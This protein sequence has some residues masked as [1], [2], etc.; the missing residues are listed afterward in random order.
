MH[1]CWILQ[2]Q[3]VKQKTFNRDRYHWWRLKRQR[4]SFLSVIYVCNRLSCHFCL[5]FRSITFISEF[6]LS[7]SVVLMSDCMTISVTRNADQVNSKTS[8]DAFSWLKYCVKIVL[9]WYVSNDEFQ[10]LMLFLI[11]HVLM[12]MLM[13]ILLIYLVWCDRWADSCETVWMKIN[14]VSNCLN[15][16]KNQRLEA[17]LSCSSHASC[18]CISSSRV[19]T[20]ISAEWHKWCSW[21]S[22][23]EIQSHRHI[24][25]LAIAERACC[26]AFSVSSCQLSF[27]EMSDSDNIQE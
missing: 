18:S 13:N 21:D 10:I 22:R 8:S 23:Q 14:I 24:L 7:Q 5:Y 15:Q 26:V 9:K 17:Y 2:K 12:C 3:A 27:I 1:R 19:R 25:F 20:W 11:F 4:R 16:M 6:V